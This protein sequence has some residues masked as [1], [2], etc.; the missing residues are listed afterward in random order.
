MNDSYKYYI[1]ICAVMILNLCSCKKDNPVTSPD[2]EQPN[3][4]YPLALGNRWTY[5]LINYDTSG[6]AKDTSIFTTDIQSDTLIS[7][8]LWFLLTEFYYGINRSDGFY[9]YFLESNKSH[10]YFKYPTF[11]GDTATDDLDQ[12]LKT[13]SVSDTVELNGKKYLAYR[14]EIKYT[15]PTW[16]D[17]NYERYYLIPKI[18]LVRKEYCSP[19]LDR[20]NRL[21]ARST[22]ISYTLN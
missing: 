1:I 22:L 20:L 2:K 19:Y 7:N 6:I 18:G 4:I 3:V 5:Q 13:M 9:I 21:F 17:S 16:N 14:Y 15:N 8:E 12:Y 10:L 11:V